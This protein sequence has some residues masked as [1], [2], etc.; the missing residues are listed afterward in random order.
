MDI[1]T[2]VSND[3]HRPSQYEND[4]YNKKIILLDGLKILKNLSEPSPEA[5]LSHFMTHIE[6]HQELL[7][8]RRFSTIKDLASDNA[9][10]FSDLCIAHFQQVKEDLLK[11]KSDM[12][13]ES[14]DLTATPPAQERSMQSGG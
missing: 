12:P 11:L 13:K 6:T 3:I 4:V 9:H 10:S 1:Q 2:F 8:K 14:M 5:R 7:G